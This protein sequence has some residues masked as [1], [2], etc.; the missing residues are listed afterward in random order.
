MVEAIHRDLKYDA[1]IIV[2][3]PVCFDNCST[4]TINCNHPICV[5]CLQLLNKCNYVCPLCRTELA[6]PEEDEYDSDYYDNLTEDQV[7]EMIYNNLNKNH[8]HDTQEEEYD[9]DDSDN[10]SLT[11]EQVYE[12]IHNNLNKSY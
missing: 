1:N 11:E 6:T 9:S 3:C 10:D 4:K 2:E 12:I 7:Y 8:E 5:E